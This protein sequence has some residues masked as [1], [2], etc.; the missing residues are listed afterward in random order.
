M[1]RIGTNTSDFLYLFLVKA[2]VGSSF[3]SR[4]I[5]MS[6]ES[7]ECKV[8]ESLDLVK[9]VLRVTDLQEFLSIWLYKSAPR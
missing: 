5:S 3:F 4:V 2:L 1:G 6:F 7:R 8:C 9:R